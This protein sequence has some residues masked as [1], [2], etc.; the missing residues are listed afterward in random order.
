MIRWYLVGEEKGQHEDL[1]IV[2]VESGRVNQRVMM[3]LWI[4]VTD[5]PA[6]SFGGLK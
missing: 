2:K 3:E 6:D 4:W 5:H 1:T